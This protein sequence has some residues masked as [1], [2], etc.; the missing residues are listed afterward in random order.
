[1]SES[2]NIDPTAVT[3]IHD[4]D[5]SNLSKDKWHERFAYVKAHDSYFDLHERAEYTRQTF[6]ALYRHE[7]KLTSIHSESRRCDPALWF[8]ENRK[9]RGGYALSGVTFAPGEANLVSRAGEVFGNRWRNARPKGVPGD[10]SVWIR[11]AERMIPNPTDREHVFDVMAFKRQHP[12]IKINH[13]VLHGGVPGSGKDTLWSPFLWSIGT[14]QNVNIEVVRHDEMAGAWGYILESEVLVINELRQ[15]EK[16]DKRGF[17]NALK[18]V[19]AAPPE[20]LQINRKHV[21]PYYALNRILLLAFSNERAAISLPSDDRRWFVLWSDAPRMKDNEAAA[22]WNWYKDG[23]FAAVAAWLDARDV[24]AF[25][26][27]ATPP[28]TDAK[29][30][31][32]ELAMSNAES[33]VTQMAQD[34]VAEFERGVIATPLNLLALRIVKNHRDAPKISKEAILVA[35]KEAGWIDRGYVCSRRY[36]SRRYVY[37]APEHAETPG[38][39]LRD[40]LEAPLPALTVVK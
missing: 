26:P 37:V 7:P 28:V 14:E 32:I 34:R 19:I 4:R 27:G 22:I 38:S 20:F 31:L 15:N 33:Y 13:A 39:K 35:L 11:H 23:G 6:N 36:P 9:A 12:N 25:M 21:H 2:N 3:E 8:D 30:Q 1:M 16:M 10:V 17:E 40:M 29:L 5:V 24:S 18:P